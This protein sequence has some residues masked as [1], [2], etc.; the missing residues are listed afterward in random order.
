MFSAQPELLPNLII[1]LMQIIRGLSTKDEQYQAVLDMETHRDEFERAAGKKWEAMQLM[2]HTALKLLGQDQDATQLEPPKM[3]MCVLLCNSS[4]LVTPTFDPL[5]LAFDPQ[6]SF[7][8]HSC[9]PNAVVVYDGPRLSLRSLDAIKPGEEI[10]ISYIN[11]NAPFGVRQA[12]LQDQYFFSC[13]CSKCQQGTQAPQDAFLKPGSEFEERIKVIDEMLPQ[14]DKDSAWPRHVLGTSVYEQRLSALQFYAYSF[15]EAPDTQSGSAQDP[16]RF[17]KA[18]TICKNTGV[19]PITRAPLPLLY[20]QYAVS[21][22]GASRYNEALVAML[23]LHILVDPTLH[24]Q[25]HHPVRIVHA[26]TLATLAKA[27]GSD[28]DSPFC[29]ALQSCGVDLSML[30]VALLIDIHEQVPKSH[31]SESLF[32]QVV[33]DAWRSMLGPG[34][35]LDQ[36]YLQMGVKREQWQSMMP[37][38]IREL[39]GKVKSFLEDEMIAAQIDEAVMSNDA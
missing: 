11:S 17:R 25:P 1:A 29:K 39:R 32:G 22:L 16:A 23:R 26:W 13:N 14:I 33:N 10:F 37:G 31:G 9:A 18:I 28:Q 34:G 36:Q 21:C 24:P 5:G 15:L 30:F 2:T 4:R 12:E 19:Y 35:E 8:N 27:V 20:H 7:V 38:Q 3:A 6:T